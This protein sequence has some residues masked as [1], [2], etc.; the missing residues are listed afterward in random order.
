MQGGHV[1][2]FSKAVDTVASFSAKV[3]HDHVSLK[4]KETGTSLEV[5]G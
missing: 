1:M 4:E 2:A 5:Q 3:R